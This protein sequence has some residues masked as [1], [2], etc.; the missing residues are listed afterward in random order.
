MS[1][2]YKK[3]PY[4]GDHKGKEKKKSANH[5]IRSKLKNYDET[6]SPAGYKKITEPWDI[7]DY[8]SYCTYESYRE[9]I[10][11]M[12]LRPTFHHLSPPNEVEMQRSWRKYYY[13]K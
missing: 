13:N 5:E 3:H 12:Y 6:L 8:W 11:K 4:G 10:L 7:C 1:R 9:A 2:S